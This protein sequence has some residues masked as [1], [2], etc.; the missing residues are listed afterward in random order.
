MVTHASWQ[1]SEKTILLYWK[2]NNIET[3]AT[4]KSQAQSIIG[5]SR[6]YWTADAQ[7]PMHEF[8]HRSW[9][10]KEHQSDKLK[11]WKQESCDRISRVY[12]NK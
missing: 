11:N 4:V 9:V 12:L 3:G 2:V 7:L 10:R 5:A 1:L 6:E 8:M